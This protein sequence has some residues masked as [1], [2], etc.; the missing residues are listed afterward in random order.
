MVMINEIFDKK[1]VNQL[2]IGDELPFDV[3]EDVLSYMRNDSNFY[4]KNTYPAMCD[5]QEKVQNGGKFSKKSLF[6]MIEKACE[7]YCAEYNI[8]KRHEELMSDAD[9][10]ECA[11]RLLN[12]EKEAFR[13]KEY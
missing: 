8:P 13:N 2:K 11:S 3:I 9:K 1:S 4:R 10:M 6:P 7:S 12:A 5:V